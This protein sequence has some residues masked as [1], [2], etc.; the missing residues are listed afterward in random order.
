MSPFVEAMKTCGLL[1]AG[2]DERVH[3]ERGADRE[4]AAGLLPRLAELDVQAL[5]RERVL[6]EYR[7]GVARTERRGGDRGPT[8]PAPTTRTNIPGPMLVDPLAPGGAV[9][10]TRQCALLTT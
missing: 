5:V 10:S 3:L 2:L 7:D 6:V 4:A 8:R 1:D 9:S